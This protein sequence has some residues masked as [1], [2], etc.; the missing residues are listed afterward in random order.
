[1]KKLVSLALAF[2]C[3]FAFVGCIPENTVNIK[4]PFAVEDIINI[5]MYRSSASSISEMKVIESK[6]DIKELYETFERISYKN[7]DSKETAP[8]EIT[9]FRFNLSDG[10]NYELVYVGYGVKDGRLYSSTG[11]FDYFTSADIGW[12][13]KWLNE[14]LTAV[15]VDETVIPK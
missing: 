13:W 8:P 7:K 1:M 2:V 11:K 12:Y 3:I 4:F 5:E 9:A 6:E 14:E 15:P 10:T